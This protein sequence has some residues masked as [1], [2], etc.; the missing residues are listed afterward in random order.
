MHIPCSELEY[1]R[2]SLLPGLCH[3]VEGKLLK[4]AIVTVLVGS[5]KGRLGDGLSPQA[6]VEAF[7]PMGFESH[8]HIAQTLSV[9][10]LTEHQSQKL[11]P[12]GEM[13]NILIST[14]FTDEIIEMI[15]IE[16]RC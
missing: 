4:D 13:L 1:V 10:E 3:H 11:V 6:E 8:Y 15:P 2:C 12:A 9:A 16:E 14:I 7:R 5:S